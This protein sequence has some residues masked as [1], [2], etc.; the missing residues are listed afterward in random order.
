VDGLVSAD[1]TAGCLVTEH[2]GD[3]GRLLE[4]EEYGY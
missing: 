1:G 2:D 4:T 3:V